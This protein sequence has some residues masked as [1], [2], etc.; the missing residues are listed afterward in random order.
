MERIWKRLCKRYGIAFE[1]CDEVLRLSVEAVIAQ[2]AQHVFIAPLISHL[3]STFCMRTFP[4]AASTVALAFAMS[5]CSSSVRFSSRGVQNSS[6]PS[7]GGLFASTPATTPSSGKQTAAPKTSQANAS[8]LK[9]SDMNFSGIA[10]YYGDEF[11]GRKTANGEIYDRSEFSAAHRSLPFGTYLKV[12]NL[13]SDRSV[14]V[15]VNDRGPFKA[16][17]VLDVSFAAAQELGLVKTGTAEV[18]VTVME[19]Q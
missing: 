14:I 18:E 17:R 19:A 16:T 11:H 12:R 10:S 2:I 15:R 5:A 13:S 1:C 9:T 7:N 6:P 3:F 4:L 8:T